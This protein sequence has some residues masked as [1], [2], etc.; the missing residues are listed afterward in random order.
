MEYYREDPLVNLTFAALILLGGIGFLVWS[1]LAGCVL[2]RRRLSV[3]SRFILI[4]S[5]IL[6]VGGAVIFA[7]FEWN[8]PASLGG[9]S[10]V[11]SKLIASLFQSVTWR[12][13]G[14]YMIPNGSFLPETLLCGVLFMFVGGA[15]GST[16]GGVKM[17]TV[18]IFGWTV[19][20]RAFGRKQTVIFRRTVSE[21]S[22]VRA[23][24][25]I[26]LQVAMILVG[27]LFL[28]LAVPGLGATEVLSEVVSAIS[29]VGVTAGITSSMNVWGKLI[30][31]VLMYL[32]RIGTV[33]VTYSM[34][35]RADR[36]SGVR[37]PDAG[38]PIG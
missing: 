22:F 31:M 32:G 18:G 36:D 12:T 9:F 2:K 27:I 7:I 16:A 29:T 11:P 21:N 4:L 13:A 10:S 19:I 23:A 37:Y 20:C 14:F 5:A 3:Y 1:D 38:M 15:S 33:T 28:V 24:T 35:N 8:N 25:V 34:M 30:L 17:G 26:S 6:V